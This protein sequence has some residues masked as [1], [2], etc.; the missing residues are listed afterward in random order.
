MTETDPLRRGGE[1]N[2]WD[3]RDTCFDSKVAPAHSPCT[4][5]RDPSRLTTSL[6]PST[7]PLGRLTFAYTT[8]NVSLPD[9]HTSKAPCLNAMSPKHVDVYQEFSLHLGRAEWAE[10]NIVHRYGSLLQQPPAQNAA[11]AALHHDL[12]S[13][14]RDHAQLQML[15]SRT[16]HTRILFSHLGRGPH[17]DPAGTTPQRVQGGSGQHPPSP[18]LAAWPPTFAG[19][20][21]GKQQR[22]ADDSATTDKQ[23][24]KKEERTTSSGNLPKNA[25]PPRNTRMAATARR[26]QRAKG[27][28][29]L[30]GHENSGQ[31]AAATGTQHQ[32]NIEADID[33]HRREM[34][35]ARVSKRH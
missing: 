32:E 3:M 20:A 8:S 35:R 31:P 17:V 28:T 7:R 25:T 12:K 24:T 11:Y 29:G 18:N 6:C 27:S 13:D 1:C 14:A 2:L 15:E 26:D 9:Y 10:Q 5:Q 16:H 30:E 19:K 23:T 33:Q 21:I 34:S 4:L 22:N